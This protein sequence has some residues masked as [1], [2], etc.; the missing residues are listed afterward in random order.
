LKTFQ[1]Q[2]VQKDFSAAL[3]TLQTHQRKLPEDVFHY[4][5]GLVKA[6]LEDLA[7]ARYHFLMS[8]KKGFGGPELA[9]NQSLIAHK[10][11]LPR[12]EAALN[13]TDYLYKFA[14]AAPWDL[15]T[16]A[17]LMILLVSLVWMKKNVTPF[18]LFILFVFLSLPLG[19]GV[20]AW[21]LDNAVVIQSAEI[22]DGPSAIFGTR[23]EL[24]MGVQI[25]TSGEGEWKKVN[26]PSRF[27][28]WVKSQSLRY[29]E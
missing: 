21:T 19:V 22:S 2:Y 1:G 13:G 29:L 14:L 4:N 23:G 16:G 8:A 3:Q 12:W 10:L 20:W 28:G 5:V 7:L 6:Q 15:L 11:D 18:R 24:P 25:V 17:I 27:A 9:H 26:Y